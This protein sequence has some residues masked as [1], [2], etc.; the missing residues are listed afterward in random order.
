MYAACDSKEKKYKV[1]ELLVDC[2]KAENRRFLKI[3]SDGQWY[4]M[5]G[6]KVRKKASQQLRERARRGGG[7]QNVI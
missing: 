6:N 4:E 5:V 3:E 7:F 1:S 2:M